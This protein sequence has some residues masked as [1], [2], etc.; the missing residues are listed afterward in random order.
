MDYTGRETLRETGGKSGGGMRGITPSGP[1]LPPLE[2]G[3]LLSSTTPL[4]VFPPSMG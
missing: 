1:N 3:P 2:P 4:A